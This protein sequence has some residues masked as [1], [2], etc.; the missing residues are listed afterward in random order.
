M[1]PRASKP[2]TLIDLMIVV[3][4]SAI[5]MTAWRGLASLP[6]MGDPILAASWQGLYFRA[7]GAVPLLIT[8]SLS[9]LLMSSFPPRPTRRR[10]A[11]GPIGVVGLSVLF[12]LAAD[13]LLILLGSGLV[14]FH[15]ISEAFRTG[16]VFYFLR[17]IAEH[18]GMAIGSAWFAAILG[19]GR[20]L[21]RDPAE[22]LAWI[23]GFCW[24]ALALTSSYFMMI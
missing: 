1:A 3:G 7:L 13:T 24:V 23:L 21:P 11:R 22:G 6:L 8:L 4:A 12:A 5:G 16:K 2:L 19:G 14:G 9:P 17:A 15:L 18:S 20:A 10:L